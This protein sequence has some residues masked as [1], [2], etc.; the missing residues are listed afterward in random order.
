MNESPHITILLAS[1]NRLVFLQESLKSCMEQD[2]ENY[3]V[4]IVDDGSGEETRAWLNTLGPSGVEVVFQENQGVASARQNGLLHANGEYVCILDSDDQ[5]AGG[6]LTEMSRYIETHPDAVI[7]YANNREVH[8]NGKCRDSGY[9][10]YLDACTFSRAV[11][12]SLRVPFKHSGTV[13]KKNTAMLL[14]GYDANLACKIDIDFIL[15]FSTNGYLP[16]LM[17]QS[18]VRFAFHKDSISRNRWIG[19]KCWFVILRRYTF[20]MNA[21]T[22][23]YV[24]LRRSVMEVLKAVYEKTVL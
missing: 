2:Y 21:L 7:F 11:M 24:I 6:A 22:R 9:K 16:V 10:E 18:L 12:T 1:Y 20:H 19:I 13:F 3:D 8:P 5:L 15:K 14:G 4:L 23:S 17:K